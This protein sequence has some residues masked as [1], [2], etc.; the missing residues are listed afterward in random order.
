MAESTSATGWHKHEAL[1]EFL[2]TG[3]AAIALRW[4]FQEAAGDLGERSCQGGFEDTMH[5]LALCGR[6]EDCL[7]VHETRGGS[8]AVEPTMRMLL[9]AERAR[10]V[11]VK[12][13]RLTKVQQSVCE[14]QYGATIVMGDSGIS[15]ALALLMPTAKAAHAKSKAATPVV[16]LARLHE[17]RK[18]DE[19][20]AST[21]E[22]IAEEAQA[23]LDGVHVRIVDRRER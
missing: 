1:N 13:S 3:A 4:F 11:G 16:T 2:S 8:N 17:R 14:A 12:L 21:L 7:A 18:K 10:A 20:A 19:Q 23:A 22:R 9:A 6:G 5:R 15:L